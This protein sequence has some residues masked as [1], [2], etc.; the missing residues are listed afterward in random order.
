M[1]S[2]AIENIKNKK[3]CQN[4]PGPLQELKACPIV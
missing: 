3:N 4:I 1:F 2:L